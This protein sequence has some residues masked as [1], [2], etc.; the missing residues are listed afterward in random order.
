M[1]KVIIALFLFII[2]IIGYMWFGYANIYNRIGAGGLKMADTQYT[3]ELNSLNSREIKYSALGDSLTAGVGA[4][5]YNESYPYILASEFS[6]E[7]KVVLKDFSLLGARTEDLITKNLLKNAVSGKPNIV[8]LLVGVNDVR[9]NIND[10]IFKSNY[11][12]IVNE[13]ISG[14]KADIYLINIPFIGS[15]TFYLPPYNMYFK[16]KTIKFNN[17]IKEIATK[18]NLIYIDIANPTE[19]IFKKDSFYYSVD[20]FHPSKEGYK[21]LAKIIYDNINY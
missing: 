3:Y 4:D 19:Q 21:I 13:L 16:N 11:E 5:N 17:I 6:K 18:Y 8:T 7:N 14:T 10:D 20:S 15:N 9:E 1:K 2:L 12:Y